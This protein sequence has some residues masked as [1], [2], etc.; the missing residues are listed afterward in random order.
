MI[1]GR[2]ITLRAWELG[3]VATFA[4]WFN[5]PEVTIN[6]GNA[7]PSLSLAEEEKYVRENLSRPNAYAITLNEGGKMIGN[8]DLHAIDAH[9]R[10]A[11]LGIVIGEKEYWNQGYGREAVGMLLQVGFA[12]LG[13]NRISLLVMDLNQRGYRCYRAAGFKEEGRLRQR[14]YIRGSFH[15]EIIMSLLAEEYWA[16]HPQAE[17]T[18]ESI[19]RWLAWL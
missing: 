2:R 8:C 15:D 5:D 14:A 12:G 3:D 9:N 17:V 7:Y 13:L 4:R 6:L 10:C 18:A 16:N 1:I 19:G 11:E